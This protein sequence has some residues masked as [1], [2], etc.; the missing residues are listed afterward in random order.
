MCE[1]EMWAA[2][3][4]RAFCDLKG[5]GKSKEVKMA[6]RDARDWFIGN[7]RDFRYVCVQAGVDP[8]YVRRKA[9]AGDFVAG[10]GFRMAGTVLNFEHG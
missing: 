9:L 3:L 6:K 7:S 5:K 8:D 4:H 10:K 2:V 1:R